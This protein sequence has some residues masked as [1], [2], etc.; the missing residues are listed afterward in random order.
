MEK[1]GQVTIF[2]IVAIILVSAIGGFFII[3][4]R[5]IEKPLSTEASSVYLFVESCI[6]ETGEEVIYWIGRGGGYYFPPEFSTE[7]GIPYYFSDNKNYM[8]SK[9]EVEKEISNFVSEMLFFCTRNFINFPDLEIN[10]GEI[11]TRTEVK[12]EEVILNI[13]YPL[14]IT[15]GE[16]TSRLEDFET[17]IPMRLGIVYNSVEEFIKEQLTHEDICLSCI[18]DIS[19][20]EDLYIDMID[21]DSETVVFLFRDEYSKINNETFEF[22]FANR[23]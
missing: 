5:I 21:Y 7:T 9:A 13:K 19:L 2:I 6:K 12:D 3:R 18:L 23:Y 11:R 4:D 20:K 8:P 10:Q 17:K 16:S 22:V 15:K 1:R 14:S